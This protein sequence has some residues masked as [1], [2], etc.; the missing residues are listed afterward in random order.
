MLG[1]HPHGLRVHPLRPI[2]AHDS[3]IALDNFEVDF[4]QFGRFERET[5]R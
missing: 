3:D 4:T 1:K 5:G 2:D